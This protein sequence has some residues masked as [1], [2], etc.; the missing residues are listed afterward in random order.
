MELTLQESSHLVDTV[1]NGNNCK[2]ASL[3]S[4]NQGTG[5]QA[6]LMRA[7]FE[8]FFVM[9]VHINSMIRVKLSLNTF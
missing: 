2:Q 3:L 6:V 4:G 5:S 9:I 8:A 7:A 1:L